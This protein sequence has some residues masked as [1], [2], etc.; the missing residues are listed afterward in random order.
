MEEVKV[1]RAHEN[2]NMA[3]SHLSLK[4]M[5]KDQVGMGLEGYSSTVQVSYDIC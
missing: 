1:P 5:E 4:Q 2:Y 3:L